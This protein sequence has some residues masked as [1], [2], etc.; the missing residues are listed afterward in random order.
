M[1]RPEERVEKLVAALRGRM[2]VLKDLPPIL[3]FRATWR[4]W[5][6]GSLYGLVG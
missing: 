1:I 4:C 3:D 5:I 6:D 2:L